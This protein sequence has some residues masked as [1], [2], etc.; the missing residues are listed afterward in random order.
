MKKALARTHQLG[1]ILF[2]FSPPFITLR[3]GGNVEPPSP[4]NRLLAMLA[5][6]RSVDSD[7]PR[8]VKRWS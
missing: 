1:R 2:S 5:I 3:R 6:A 4:V 8:E 7:Q